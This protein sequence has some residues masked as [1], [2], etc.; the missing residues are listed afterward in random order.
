MILESGILREREFSEEL[1]T[2]FALSL[3]KIFVF[4]L[5]LLYLLVLV[6]FEEFGIIFFTYLRKSGRNS[7]VSNG[8]NEPWYILEMGILCRI[9]MNEHVSSFTNLY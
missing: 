6:N 7:N 5:L 4:C 3:S 8:K 9:K 2:K 1:T